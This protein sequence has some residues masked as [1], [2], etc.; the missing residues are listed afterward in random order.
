MVL[1]LGIKNPEVIKEAIQL[2][3]ASL[4]QD[5]KL[6]PGIGNNETAYQIVVKAGQMAYAESYK[7]VYLT[8]IAFGSVSIIA[9]CFLGEIDRYMDDH[10]AVVM[11]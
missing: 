7:Y 9:S 2:T 10:V 4:L 3:G 11:R 8:S 5:L 6:L 1:E